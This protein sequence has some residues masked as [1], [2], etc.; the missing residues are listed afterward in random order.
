MAWAVMS[1]SAVGLVRNTGASRR[2]E[3]HAAIM[4]GEVLW[5][6]T[7]IAVS[8]GGTKAFSISFTAEL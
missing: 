6:G 7:T 3:R 4:L 2:P 8:A 5:P 1:G